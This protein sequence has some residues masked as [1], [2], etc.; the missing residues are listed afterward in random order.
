MRRVL[1]VALIAVVGI[2]AAAQAAQAEV[3]VVRDRWGVPHVFAANEADG[4]FAVGYTCAQDRLV[5]MEL[6]RRRAYGRLAELFGPK[7]VESDR[8]FRVAGVQQYC[9]AAVGRL[10]DEMRAYLKAYAAG[11]NAYIK[12]N[13]AEVTKRFAVVGAAPA[14]W[15]PADCIA[16]WLSMS[17]L[18]DR[19][20][21]ESHVGA[22]FELQRLIMALGETEALK[23]RKVQVDDAAAIVPESEMAKNKDAYKR[24]KAAKRIPGY[25]RVGEKDE[26]VKFSHAWAVG[27]AKS[28][29]GKP[30]LESDPQTPVNNPAL[31]HEWH[32][33]AGRYDVRGVS[34]PGCPAMLIGFNRN[35]A[36]GVTALGVNSGVTYVEKLSDDGKG[37]IY[38]GKTVPFERRLEKIAVK[39]GP[40][41]IQEVLTNRHGFVFNSLARKNYAGEGYVSHHQMLQDKGTSMKGMLMW[42]RASNW[43]EFRTAMREY[44]SPGCHLVYADSA[45]NIGY[46][47][48]V[49][50]PR[51]RLSPRIA[52]EGWTGKSE[53]GERIPLDEM[54]NMLNPEAGFISHANNMPVGSWYPYDIGLGTG[55]VG[56]SPRSWRLVQ[57][58]SQDKKFS[59][60]TFESEV[61]RDSVNPAVAALLPIARKVAQEDGADTELAIGRVLKATKGW[62][63]RTLTSSEAYPAGKALSNLVLSAYRGNPLRGIVGGGLGGVC[64][65][66]RIAS[67][68]FAKTGE[69]PKDQRVR[70]Y[71]LDWLA[72]AGGGGRG[73]LRNKGMRNY[74][75]KEILRTAW[76]AGGPMKL[77]ALDPK[78][79]LVSPP[80]SCVVG[81]TIW[82][83]QGNCYTQ[84]V[85]LGD[86]DNSRSIMPPGNSEIIASKHQADQ[87]DLWAKGR[88]RPAPLSRKKIDALA[89]STVKLT[90][91]AYKGPSAP[92][93]MLADDWK[94][95]DEGRFIPAIPRSKARAKLPGAPPQDE[96]LEAAVRYLIQRD[97]TKEEID[98]KIDWIR[99]YIKGHKVRTAEMVSGL[100]LLIYVRYGTDYA[101]EQFR[102][103]LL[104]LGGEL[105]PE[106]PP[107]RRR[108]G[109]GRRGGRGG[110][111]R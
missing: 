57:L 20:Y 79:D 16:T 89:E 77:P 25:L 38:K 55:G 32:L 59:V 31:F 42:M 29:T 100:R 99:G 108:R 23:R 15:T 58:L 85:D 91:S 94:R 65:L 35:V 50:L 6:L 111:G 43:P 53:I 84:I 71:L 87:V 54:P 10:P 103:L 81:S 47:T 41:V 109:G 11:V 75:R 9:A 19:T 14:P 72:T 106:G 60:E 34:V 51:T 1:L 18:F 48:L 107:P 8:K 28:V 46:Q 93:P 33:S 30:I 78:G 95:G 98:A 69:T 90:V 5:Q 67:A 82:S 110:G 45:G 4:F 39:G 24:L 64:R 12:A 73:Y 2:V 26:N 56:H 52:L 7:Y 37:F 92:K 61:H 96:K 88:T 86:I 76:Q 40:P 97:R 3:E 66:G 62:D 101:K 105:P 36:W 80:L 70:D 21:N 83:Q 74:S 102:K 44:Y 63:Y 13:P 68:R 22:Y 49:Y 104:E 27:G 17:V